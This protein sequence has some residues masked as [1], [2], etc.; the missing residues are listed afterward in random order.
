VVTAL[1]LGFVKL[2]DHFA[3]RPVVLTLEDFPRSDGF[4]EV[5]ARP[6]SLYV[7]VDDRVWSGLT[8]EDRRYLVG[9]M[10][11]VLMTS[12]YT[13]VLLRDRERRPLAQWLV[14]DGVT[15]LEKEE[16]RPSVGTVPA[17]VS[18][19]NTVEAQPQASSALS[20]ASP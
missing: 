15:L 16:T 2:P 18:S 8:E 6:P 7:T 13:G 11:S 9:T 10:S 17:H 14:M 3:A 4:L 5:T 20:I 12:G 1:W 19:R